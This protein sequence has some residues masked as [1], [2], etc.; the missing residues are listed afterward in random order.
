MRNW[1]KTTVEQDRSKLTKELESRLEKALFSRETISLEIE[2]IKDML[3]ITKEKSTV[4]KQTKTQVKP[5]KKQTKKQTK[6]TTS[7]KTPANKIEMLLLKNGNHILT[8]VNVANK[9]GKLLQKYSALNIHTTV[10]KWGENYYCF[11]NSTKAM[12]KT[13]KIVEQISGFKYIGERKF[14]K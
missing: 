11:V 5:T 13:I 7:N 4:K 12:N 2:H 1:F 3:E 10:S 14:Q 6:Q 9:Q 8:G